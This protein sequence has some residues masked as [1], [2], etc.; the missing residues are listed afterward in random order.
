MSVTA[1]VP[2]VWRASVP[3]DGMSVNVYLV[4]DGDAA[5]LV[6]TAQLTGSR[7]AHLESLLEAAGVSAGAVR[8]VVLTH[9]HV[10]H[11][12]GVPYVLQRTGT[13]VA[14]HPQETHTLEVIGTWRGLPD[15]DSLTAWH[16]ERGTPAAE[17]SQIARVLGPRPHVDVGEPTWLADGDVLPVGGMRWRV[18]H[19]PGHTNGHICL[20]EER[21]RLLIT[22]DHIIPRGGGNAHVT[23]RP[24]A[25]PNPL[26]SYLDALRRLAQLPVDWCLPG[27]GEPVPGVSQV[28]SRHLRHHEEKLSQTLRTIGEQWLTPYQ[29]AASQLWLGNRQ[30]FRALTEVQKFLGLGEIMARLEHLVEL[31]QAQMVQ[32]G[33]MILIRRRPPPVSAP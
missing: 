3:V 8:T 14:L 17:A 22:G 26:R 11:A 33:A 20:Y 32:D 25:I 10:D 5:L 31:G 6:D 12:G 15:W 9:A 29:I 23:A 27:H 1:V 7:P 4:A 30:P 13:R 19:T 2:G 24:G 16:R 18:L 28:A 21:R